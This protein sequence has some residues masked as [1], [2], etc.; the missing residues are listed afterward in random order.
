MPKND[1]ISRMDESQLRDL[2]HALT[3]QVSEHGK[4]ISQLS[5]LVCVRDQEIALRDREIAARVKEIARRDQDL[6]LKEQ[7]I[8]WS[9]A[10]IAML[11][12]EMAVLKRWKF[13]R[14][15]EGLNADQLSLLDET[16]DADLEAIETELEALGLDADA[17]K[18]CLPRQPRRTPLPASLARTEFRHEP[19]STL[20]ANVECGAPMQR[21]GESVS[22][23]L[24]YTPGVFSVERHVRGKWVCRCC[25]KL[26]QAPVPAHVIDKGI[27]TAGLLAQVL[28]AKYAD[29][30]PLAR[31]ENIFA[32]AGVGIARSTLAAWVG[33]CGVQ[34][35]SL[36]DALRVEVLAC[37]V[38]HADETPVQM[39]KP[40]AG[41]THRA[42]LWAYAAG[43]FEPLR[44]VIYDFCETR[45]GKNASEFLAGWRGHLMVDDFSGYK[46]LF[47]A[48]GAIELGCLAHARRKFYDLHATGGSPVGSKALE[49]FG[50]IYDIEREM[51]DAGFEQ[52]R[53]IRDKY[54]RPIVDAL[55]EWMLLQR[56]QVPDGT[57][58]AKALDYSLRRWVALTR[59]L[60]DGR[61]P[62]DNNHLESQ[63]RPIAVGRHNWL[64]AGSLRA[65]KRAAAVMTLVNSAKLNGH[66]PFAYMKDVLQRLPTQRMSAI[67]ELLPHR[68]T[69]LVV[70]SDHRGEML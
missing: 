45:A 25:E 22:E 30:L 60:N 29:H 14:S 63:I 12:H 24:D 59:F 17:G 3:N 20:C 32:R 10:R 62:V 70:Q 38:L 26:V 41:K 6:Q 36:V 48:D 21:I 56:Q 39:L 52:R 42:Y 51:R 37:P 5:E 40:G 64:F 19:E 27:P 4:H 43:A 34:L 7:Q 8:K 55:H 35:Q 61:F 1:S 67:G 69:P 46:A 18:V 11:T 57:A 13:G 44:A 23:K 50:L 53:H 66:D 9:E 47:V 54:A 16:I 2:V 58:T 49:Y 68:W 31:Q 28:V 15:R 33:Q 65:G